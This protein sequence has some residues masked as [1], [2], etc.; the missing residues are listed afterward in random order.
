MIL[1][2]DSYGDWVARINPE[3]IHILNN[4]QFL[5]KIKF[6]KIRSLLYIIIKLFFDNSFLIFILRLN[7]FSYVYIYIYIYIYIL[8][9]V[10]VCVCL[11]M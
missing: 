10:C 6:I 5:L 7:L 3:R 8:V 1:T 9:Y 11:C 4:L 2:G